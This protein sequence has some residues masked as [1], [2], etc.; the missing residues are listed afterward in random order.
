MEDTNVNL[1]QR[2]LLLL[3]SRAVVNEQVRLR[4]LRAVLNRYIV[5]GRGVRDDGKPRFRV[6]R[7]LL[8]DVVRYWRTICVDYAAKKWEQDDEKW[9]LRNAKLRVSRKLLFVKGLLLCF[10]CELFA[11]REPWRNPSLAIGEGESFLEERQLAGI[12]W[13]AEFTPLD[14]L[15]RVLLILEQK[16]LAERI[17]SRYNAF[18]EF[19]DDAANRKHLKELTFDA[20][21]TNGLFKRMRYEIGRE[22]GRALEEL[23]FRGPSSLTD[24]TQEYGVF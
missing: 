22:F 1:T 4:V 18:L 13:L 19:M 24:L 15:S 23:F 14:L 8:N 16:G 10:D 3:E 2:L 9:A 21:E 17:L 5:C 6:P 11:E 20:A 12:E 7:F